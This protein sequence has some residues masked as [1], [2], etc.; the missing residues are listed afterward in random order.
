MGRHPQRQEGVMQHARA[1][2][3]YEGH[4]LGDM[5]G[6]PDVESCG[7]SKRSTHEGERAVETTGDS[8]QTEGLIQ[9]GRIL[10]VRGPGFSEDRIKIRKGKI[11]IH[12]VELELEVTV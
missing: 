10:R 5:E 8:L 11:K 9:R 4:L 7:Q 6:E 3:Q 1:R 2:V 12:G